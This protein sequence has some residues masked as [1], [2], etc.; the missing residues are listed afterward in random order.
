MKAPYKKPDSVKELERLADEAARL[1]HPNVKPEWLAPRKYRDDNANGLTRCVI[2]FLKLKGMQAERISS[3]GRYLDRTKRFTDV[4]G[5]T[6][7]IGTGKW[8]KGNTTPGTA[9]IA[10]TIRG[11]SVKIEVKIGRDRQSEAQKEYQ[12]E[13][14]TAGGIYLITRNFTEFIRQYENL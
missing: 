14:E 5:N 7:Q 2:D 10:S 12:L 9:D 11:R 8:I 13:V 3:T 1:K 6:R 4:L